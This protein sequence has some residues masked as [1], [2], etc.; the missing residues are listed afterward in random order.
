MA[1][2]GCSAAAARALLE[3]DAE[4]NDTSRR[5][6]AHRDAAPAA[7][8]RPASRLRIRTLRL[9][10]R[11]RAHVLAL[12]LRAVLVRPPPLRLQLLLRLPADGRLHALVLQCAPAVVLVALAREAVLVLQ[13]L[14]LLLAAV[15]Q[16]RLRRIWEEGLSAQLGDA[17]CEGGAVTRG[18]ESIAATLQ[19]APRATRTRPIAACGR[20][21]SPND[22][23]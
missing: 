18:L 1:R 9:S 5:T 8:S 14:H 17:S 23:C 20:A 22:F 21:G 10:N 13:Q 4:L 7:P 12:Q 2:G 11:A 15:V 16:R 19:Q 6:A 3:M